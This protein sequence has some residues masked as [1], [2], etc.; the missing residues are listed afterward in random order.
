MQI[1]TSCMYNLS[2]VKSEE[3][4]SQ[5]LPLGLSTVQHYA[6]PFGELSTSFALFYTVTSTQTSLVL[7]FWPAL[8]WLS[9]THPKPSTGLAMGSSS[10]YPGA[11]RRLDIK[12]SVAGQYQF[13]DNLLLVSGVFW[14]RPHPSGQFQQQLTVEI[15]HC[16][17][18]TSSTNLSFVRAHALLPGKS[19]L[20]IQAAWRTWLIHWVQLVR[21]TRAEPV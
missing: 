17:K 10:P 4:V 6:I 19:A 12:A 18:M 21:I 16:A 9:P 5:L 7:K 11:Q 13:P 20:H 3:P 2:A 15:Q 14:L 1:R 8:V